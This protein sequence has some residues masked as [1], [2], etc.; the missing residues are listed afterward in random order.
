MMDDRLFRWFF[1]LVLVSLLSISGYFRKKAR[2]SGD[3]VSRTDEGALAMV[4]RLAFALPLFVSFVMYAVH[5]PWMAWA[6]VAL[7]VWVRWIG[8]VFGLDTIVLV[9]WMFRSIGR[10]ISETV[11]TK[12]DHALVTKGPYR[13]I[14]HS[15]YSFGTFGF[16]SLSLI[17]ANAF[18]LI[19]SLVGLLLIRLIVIP[20]EEAN[21]IEKFGD[22]Y[23]T[24]MEQTGALFPRVF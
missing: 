14:R 15:L 13:W 8:V 12:A 24:Y 5:P 2:A 18:M 19:M 23:Q 22:E 20:R 11:L 21:L 6:V 10:N 4:L 1:I 7:P 16:L 3:T 9:L 17:A